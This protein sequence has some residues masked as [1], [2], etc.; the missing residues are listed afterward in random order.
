[1]KRSLKF[2]VVAVSV[3]IIG[4]SGQYFFPK[5]QPG[6]SSPQDKSNSVVASSRREMWKK[7]SGRIREQNKIASARESQ[8]Q[9]FDFKE[10]DA[11][12]SWAQK[13][14]AAPSSIKA[15]LERE[16]YALVVQRRAAMASLIKIDP[17]RALELSASYSL[18]TKLPSK[19]VSQFE[20]RISGRGD[21]IISVNDDPVTGTATYDRE[22]VLDGLS[23]DAFVYGRRLDQPSSLHQIALNGI[24]I[25]RVMAVNESPLRV[26]ELAEALHAAKNVSTSEKSGS[27]SVAVEVAGENQFL[28]TAEELVAMN[29]LLV[30]EEVPLSQ[31]TAVVQS[32]PIAASSWTEGTKSVLYIR[33]NFPEDLSEPVSYANADSC[34]SQVNQFY[35]SNSF[36]KTSMTWTITPVLT[37]P[38]SKFTYASGSPPTLL[39][40]AR[41]VALSAGYDTANF[42]LD[43]VV[44]KSVFSYF[45]GRGNIRS[46]GAWL[47]DANPLGA[48]HEFGHNY[49]LQH[50]NFWRASD[51]TVIGLGQDIGY[52]NPFDVMGGSVGG[53]KS[54]FSAFNKNVLNWIPTNLV[55]TV[56]SSGT[57][58]I[59]AFDTPFSLD[60]TSFYGLRIT[61]SVSTNYWVDLRRFVQPMP[62]SPTNQMLQN[63]V[64]VYWG[65][66][67]GASK[68]ETLLLDA[69]PDI[70]GTTNAYDAPFLPGHTF[71]DT[72][73][74]IHI[75]PIGKSGGNSEA[76]DVV[77]NLGTFPGNTAP[78]FSPTA[79][80]IT[81]PPETV[82][83]FTANATD[84]NGDT[85]AY[86]WD[87]GDKTFGTN[88]STG[89]K[90]W[91][92]GGSYTVKCIVSDMKGG[93]ASTNF[94]IKVLGPTIATSV[95][96]P[97]AIKS[98]T[99]TL[100][101]LGSSDDG[102]AT[103]TYTWSSTGP[104]P[105]TFT[106]NDT[107]AS[108]NTTATFSAS[109]LYTLMATIKD[110]N[111]YTVTSSRFVFVSATLTTINLTPFSVSVSNGSTQ[112]FTAIGME[113]FGGIMVTQPVF[114]WS[115]TGG[116]TINASGLFTAS[117]NGGPFTIKA[118]SGIVVG[119]A[120]VT[121]NDFFEI[122]DAVLSSDGNKFTL[123]WNAQSGWIYQVQSS[124]N[125]ISWIAETNIA[126]IS[127][128]M[129]WSDLNSGTVNRRFYRIRIQ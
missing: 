57:F 5:P 93:T 102:E 125:L 71:S 60:P 44:S 88:T 8:V 39:N 31:Q 75:T 58:R 74:G 1:V 66:T 107:N 65:V 114:A 3:M 59:T 9:A 48:S 7:F 91:K 33:V 89:S 106:P 112:Q 62:G 108:K 122:E 80:A 35:I 76:M 70:P 32:A 49:G 120:S 40:D 10:F 95:T 54:H 129:T 72:V 128:T 101:V 97:G 18:R 12:Q 56:T 69:T 38:K 113:Q 87:F 123:T 52:G 82:V 116:G 68:G 78:T 24:A 94:L 117:A 77:V 61:N 118:T 110:K 99:A 103:L 2:A 22:A 98:T 13:Y 79:S 14:M 127:S 11:F 73:K 96:N 36:G 100:S 37:L 17:K 81:V 85:L 121:V 16:G 45:A 46:K 119:T 27:A 19:I 15:S 105:V 86:Y 124:S 126:G 20:S 67:A 50:A 115:T 104:A 64:V 29:S 51:G 83:D 26:L 21:L 111:G 55:K 53:M 28:L 23:Y 47:T 84:A 25:D 42:N 4:F 34:M 92:L 41:A 6:S 30:A 109:G 90:S 43:A 63:G